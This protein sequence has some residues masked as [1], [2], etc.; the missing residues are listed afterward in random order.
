MKSLPLNIKLL[1]KIKTKLDYIMNAY[2][3]KVEI[4]GDELCAHVLRDEW[5][6]K[7]L[8]IRE[9]FTVL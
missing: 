3:T 8:K 7:N 5:V 4:R 9:V 1:R 2:G 6:K